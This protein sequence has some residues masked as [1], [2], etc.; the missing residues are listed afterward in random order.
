N[1]EAEIA[2]S[3]SLSDTIRG[4]FGNGEKIETI[5]LVKPEQ[6]TPTLAADAPA[7]SF[8]SKFAK[9]VSGISSRFFGPATPEALP[10]SAPAEVAPSPLTAQG[11]VKNF[12]NRLGP[13]I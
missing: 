3:R 12:L 13:S 6:D 10:T 9:Y 11:A 7:Q 8:T 1:R 4:W 2:T 5:E